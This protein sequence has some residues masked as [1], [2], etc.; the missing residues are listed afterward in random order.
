MSQILS[1]M[2]SRV[3]EQIEAATRANCIAPKTPQIVTC[4]RLSFSIYAL[5][6]DVLTVCYSNLDYPFSIYS[7][8]NLN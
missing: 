5:H 2:S 3:R 4:S 8:W 1:C 7:R 6:Q